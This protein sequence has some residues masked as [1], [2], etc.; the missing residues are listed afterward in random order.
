M[1][2]MNFV[3]NLCNVPITSRVRPASCGKRRDNDLALELMA[4]MKFSMYFT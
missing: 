1:L 2:L 4:K 3:D